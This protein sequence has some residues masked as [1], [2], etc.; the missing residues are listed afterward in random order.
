MQTLT[1]S[2]HQ[3]KYGP[4]YFSVWYL[5]HSFYMLVDPPMDGCQEMC[6]DMFSKYS[7]TTPIL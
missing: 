6:M 7:V 4:T 3:G 2:C 1:F 5:P